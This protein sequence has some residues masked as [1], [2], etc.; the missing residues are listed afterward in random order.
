MRFAGS[1]AQL[2]AGEGII[3]PPGTPHRFCNES[4]GDVAFLV[5]SFPKDKWDRVEI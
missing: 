4:H 5:F 1:A 2:S 3:I